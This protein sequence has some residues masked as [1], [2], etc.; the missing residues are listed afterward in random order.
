MRGRWLLIGGT[1]ILAAIGAGALMLLRHRGT[2]VPPGTSATP[3]AAPSDGSTL[4]LPGRIEALEVVPVPVPFDGTIQSLAANVGQDVFEGD[5]LAEIRSS[6]LLSQR[7]LATAELNRMTNRLTTVESNLIAA[8]LEAA[9]FRE[10]AGAA[11]GAVEDAQKALQ[12]QQMLYSKGA[13]A[14]QNLERAQAAVDSATETYEGQRG[15]AGM[16]DARAAELAKDL[17]AQQQAV[18]DK[19]K[20]LEDASDQVASGDI[21]SPVSGYVVGRKG[22]PGDEVTI[23]IQDLFLI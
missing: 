21:R 8:R 2:D 15:L 16:A 7:E 17:E 22:Q 1:L 11:R 18:A 23:D 20:E 3:A 10:S 4:T 9:R 14:R 6:D 12:R 19:S 5:L 13:T